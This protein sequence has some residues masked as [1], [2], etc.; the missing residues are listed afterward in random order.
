MSQNQKTIELAERNKVGLSFLNL[1]R[2]VD[3]TIEGDD[4]PSNELAQNMES[5]AEVLSDDDYKNIKDKTTRALHIVSVREN[6]KDINIFV[7]DSRIARAMKHHYSPTNMNALVRAMSKLNRFLSNVNTSWN[8]SFVIPNLFRDLETAGVNIQQYDEKGITKEIIFNVRSAIAGIGKNLYQNDKD[9]EWA[10]EYLLFREYGGQNATNQM[11]DLETQVQNLREIL[12]SVSENSRMG[13]LGLVKNAFLSK[14]KSLLDVLDKAN[15]AV[16]NGVRVATFRALRNRGI[17][18]E[19]AAEAARD[20]TVNFAKGGEQKAL[21]NAWFL[22]YNA[23]LQGSMALF[24]AAVKSKKVRKFWAGMIVYG[25][26]QDQVN[27]MLSGDEDEDGILDYDELSTYE[28]EH[29]LIFPIDWLT[30]SGDKMVKIPLG[31]GLNMAVNTGRALSRLARGEYTAGEATNTILATM[32]EMINPLGGTESLV[33]FAAPTI[34]DP[35]VSL[36][37]NKDYKGDPITKDSPTFAS[38]PTP[39]SHSHWSTTGEI[40]KAIVQAINNITGGNEL[41][42]GL[43]DMSPDTIQF[44]FDYVTGG[45]GRFILRTGETMIFDVPE[46][47]AGDFEGK[48]V[49]RIPLARKVIATPSE[50]ADT[51]TY[52]ENR[53]E[54][55]T[56][57]AEL[58]LA[59]RAGDVERLK[60]VTSK[61]AEELRVYGRVK[62]IDNARNRLLRQIKKIER[63][64]RLED[65]RKKQLI[66]NIRKKINDFQKQ[67]LV[68]M[69]SAGLRE[70]S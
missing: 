25:I 37:I 46:I 20:I 66:R 62:A 58:D 21:M 70:A 64:P 49:P 52:L 68:L 1:I 10:K 7:R 4:R 11:G 44:W 59:R 60:D 35:F 34:A 13:K 8:P 22:F 6:G 18:L 12:D 28:L 42:S 53:K 41:R 36:Y 19:R 5:I 31:Y 61:Y 69:R 51:G 24:N 65:E 63:N 23:S 40:P 9:S 2:G 55:F 33:N 67:G 57:F 17:T 16:E 27:A 50:V 14:G 30:G 29:N 26:L 54:L 45:A 32:T 43:V 3:N 15:T 47:L 56:I 38:V 48:I 39:D